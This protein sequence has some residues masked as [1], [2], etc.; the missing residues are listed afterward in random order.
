MPAAD[1]RARDA[2]CFP[3]ASPC[4]A[5]SAS[6]GFPDIS[7]FFVRTQSYQ[8]IQW[9]TICIN[10]GSANPNC[11]LANTNGLPAD[12]LDLDSGHRIP[13]GNL[14]GELVHQVIANN[15]MCKNLLP[16]TESLTA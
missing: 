14:F 7:T 15:I 4:P 11:G 12:Q 16:V 1:A 6:G 5:S 3:L 10:G 2:L 9:A 8:C 13:A